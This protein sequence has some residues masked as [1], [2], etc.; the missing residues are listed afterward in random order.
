MV[1]GE[2]E[3]SKT[4]QGVVAVI[5]KIRLEDVLDEE[6]LQASYEATARLEDGKRYYLYGINGKFPVD[7]GWM[8]FPEKL[9][10]VVSDL[11]AQE[12]LEETVKRFKTEMSP[13]KMDAELT[14]ID[15]GRV[16]EHKF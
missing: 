1:G 4:R 2:T 13:L 11:E 16:Y 14:V 8:I 3:E 9:G 12:F 15:K 5:E 10:R 7:M 6:G